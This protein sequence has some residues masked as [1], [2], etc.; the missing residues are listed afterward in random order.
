[1]KTTVSN[2]LGTIGSKRFK[3]KLGIISE[4]LHIVAIEI[5]NIEKQVEIK[6]DVV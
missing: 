4:V 5:N 3:S 2:L 1:M 6:S